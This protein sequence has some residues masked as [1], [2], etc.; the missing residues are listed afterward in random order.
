[1]QKIIIGVGSANKE[2]TGENP[3]TYEERKHMVELSAEAVL[4]NI[5]VEIL[6]VPD[7]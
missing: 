3:F 7:L 5:E 1:M 6:P 4:Q 2:F